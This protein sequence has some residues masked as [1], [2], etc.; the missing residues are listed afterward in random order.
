MY[1]CDGR[2]SLCEQFFQPSYS[3]RRTVIIMMLNAT[4]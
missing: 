3:T 1:N 2:T 4:C